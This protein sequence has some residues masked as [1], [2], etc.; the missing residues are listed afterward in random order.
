MTTT[1]V[2]RLKEESAGFHFI[3]GPGGCRALLATVGALLALR[4]L[5][6]NKFETIGGISGGSIP[7]AFFAAGYSLEEIT[8]LAISLDFESLLEEHEAMSSVVKKHYRGGRRKGD[9]PESG[10][11]K[12][13]RVAGWLDDKLQNKWPA[14]IPYWTMATDEKGL[15][16]LVTQEGVFKRE[17]RKLFDKLH[18]S[19]ETA[20]FWICAS[21]TVPG[22]FSP[23][24]FKTGE[25]SVM[26]LYDGALSWEGVRPISV[27]EDHYDASSGQIIMCD[28]G[29]DLNLSDTLYS[30][31]WKIV[32]GGRC[33]AHWGDVPAKD[34]S[35]LVT[36]A[37]SGVRTFE[38][39]A[40]ADKKWIAITEGFVALIAAFKSAGKLSEDQDRDARD[41]CNKLKG[42]IGQTKRLQQGRYAELTKALLMENGAL[43]K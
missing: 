6:V 40:S 4:W 26:T 42:F 9:L 37:V 2:S 22:I 21:C 41:L 17:K 30:A 32:C 3:A 10:K 18:P 29:P 12:M 28:V 34:R 8:E 43:H 25:S 16:I 36:P 33:V 14:A 15:Q 20:G 13:E 27:V 24:K 5:G 7:T 31:I 1:V 38:F 23:I 39:S 35:L 11:F 19:V